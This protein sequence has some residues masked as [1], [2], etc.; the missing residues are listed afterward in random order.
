MARKCAA[1]IRRAFGRELPKIA[2][3]LGSGLQEVVS[4][5]EV[6]NELTFSEL[7]GFAAPN[8]KGHSGSLLHGRLAGLDLL[9]LSGRAHFYEGHSME[10]VMYPIV[11]MAECGVSELVLTNAAG[12]INEAFRPGDF[13][14]FSDHLNLVGLNPLRGL[15]TSDGKCFVDMTEAYCPILRRE[16]KAAARKTRIRLRQGVYAG[17]PGPSYETPAEIRAFRILG[18]DAVGM[19]TIPEV[20]MAR[21]LGMRV[22]AISCITNLAAGMRKGSISHG[23]VL[24]KGRENARAAA[25]LFSAFAAGRKHSSAGASPYPRAG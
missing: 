18:A 11:V 24:R 21:Y 15:P 5:L 2:L 22:A 23:E 20:L 10:A 14:L 13:M 6:R 25:R 1:R 4:T 9:A 3:V 8:V 16:L 7:P 19:S 17:V 12:G